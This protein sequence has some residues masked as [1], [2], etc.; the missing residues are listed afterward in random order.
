MW[1][2][3]PESYSRFKDEWF[4]A[5]WRMCI[6]FSCGVIAR[7]WTW[8]AHIPTLRQRVNCHALPTLFRWPQTYV[9]CRVML[10]LQL[11]VI[12]LNHRHVN[13][14]L[15]MKISDVKLCSFFRCLK[16]WN[17][18]CDIDRCDIDWTR[19]SLCNSTSFLVYDICKLSPNFYWFWR[20]NRLWTGKYKMICFMPKHLPWKS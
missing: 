4:I 5:L 10:V 3:S 13:L 8:G 9:T 1:R 14:K 11:S 18:T 17:V 6:C 16:D 19:S 12:T 20:E 7:N 15:S 2:I